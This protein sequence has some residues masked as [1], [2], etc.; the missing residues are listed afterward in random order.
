MV[1]SARPNG[2]PSKLVPA[3]GARKV[4]IVH[5]DGGGDAGVEGGFVIDFTKAKRNYVDA[6]AK[7]LAKAIIS[8]VKMRFLV[9]KVSASFDVYD[10]RR[11]PS[12][13]AEYV[14]K[15]EAEKHDAANSYSALKAICA[16]NPQLMPTQEVLLDIKAVTLFGKQ[17]AVSVASP[18]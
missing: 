16:A 7:Q 15:F 5:F 18:R 13:A 10:R 12:A 17:S 4:R 9:L 11:F 6:F 1:P 8:R 2:R 14:R 3:G